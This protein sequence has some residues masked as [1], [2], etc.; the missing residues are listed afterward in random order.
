LPLNTNATSKTVHDELTNHQLLT[1]HTTSRTVTIVLLSD[2]PNK[3]RKINEDT[4]SGYY[5]ALLSA[6]LFAH[7]NE[8]G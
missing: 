3:L 2:K 8:V 7:N 1:H 5:N 6:T 4:H